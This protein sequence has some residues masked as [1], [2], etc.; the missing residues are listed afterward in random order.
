MAETKLATESETNGSLHLH[1][2][3]R[4]SKSRQAMSELFKDFVEIRNATERTG[5]DPL[6]L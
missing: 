5:S 4:V 3:S 2:Y 6:N 1:S